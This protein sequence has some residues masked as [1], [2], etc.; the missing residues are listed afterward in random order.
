MSIKS[1]LKPY[2]TPSLLR[3]YHTFQ[4]IVANVVYGF[5][6]RRLR[7]IGVTGTNGK[8]TTCHLIGAITT[9]AGYKTAIASTVAFM[10]GDGVESNGS[11]MTTPNPFVVQRFLRRAV[12]A[13]CHVAVIETTSHALDQD[14]V[15]GIRY[16]T[17]IFTNLTHD[18]L[19][20]HATFDAYRA[21]KLRL[22]A[23][24]PRIAIINVDDASAGHFLD[25]PAYQQLS[26][27]LEKKADITARKILFEPTG[28]LFTAVTP[29]GQ[30]AINLQLPGKFNVMNAL[31]AIG[32]GVGFGI[33]LDV[34]KQALE[35]VTHVAGRMERI[36]IGQ[37]FSVLVDYAH[38]P[39]AFEQIYQTLR[40]ATRGR[41]IH[42][43]GAT[44]DRDKTKRPIM[45]AL[46]ARY[47]DLVIV[48]NDEPYSEDP[49]KIIDAIVEG[50]KR[51]R[52]KQA[53]CDPT[54]PRLRGA[55]Q[56][57]VDRREDH[58]ASGEDTW[59][60][61]IAD[62]K[63]AIAYALSLARH[64]DVVLITGMGALKSMTIGD[65]RGGIHKIPWDER[66]IV[67]DLL[68]RRSRHNQ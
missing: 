47:A 32:V 16:E 39:D 57:T 41:L 58:Q 27:G 22:F 34:V 9:A 61:R 55:S 11:N 13:G 56:E 51:G 54:S 65:G 63:D 43:F 52:P 67:K 68:L 59:W 7:I 49:E 15:W 23:R 21:A 18:H 1:L 33:S 44:G 20:Y 31:A 17:V 38:T 2:A 6:S 64:T 14:R 30:V 36:D 26:F 24:Q 45:G 62:R 19:D 10:I 37:D 29:M 46:A 3:M 25:L 42:V 35:S 66:R 12:Q 60:W 8:T 28:T 53:G 5:P 4:A 48:T 50:V 40:P